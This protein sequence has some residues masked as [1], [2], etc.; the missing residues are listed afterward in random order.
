MQVRHLLLD[1]LVDLRARKHYLGH[2]IRETLR[3]GGRPVVL[4]RIK[5]RGRSNAE[6]TLKRQADSGYLFSKQVCSAID[7]S[8]KDIAKGSG[9]A[10][11]CAKAVGSVHRMN[12]CS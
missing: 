11:L 12:K 8:C 3:A 6:L 4:L 1:Q 5:V 7:R 10:L 9:L 2:A